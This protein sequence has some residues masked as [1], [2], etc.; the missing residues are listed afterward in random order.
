P[1]AT[2]T[3]CSTR[4]LIVGNDKGGIGKD[5]VAEGLTI[6]LTDLNQDHQLIEVESMKRLGHIYPHAKF[7]AAKAV[8]ADQIYANPDSIFEP[9]D[10]LATTMAQSPLNVVSLGANLSGA[11][12]QWS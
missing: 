3:A 8:G 10:K 2:A 1:K 5:L 4:A 12:I 6:G 9:M 7:I 11:F